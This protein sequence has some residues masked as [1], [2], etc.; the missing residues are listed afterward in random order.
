M[1]NEHGQLGQGAATEVQGSYSYT[2]DD[3]KT[4]SVHYKADANGGFQA[5]GDH[6][7]T[8]PPIPE[9]IQKSIA[10]NAANGDHGD[11][12]AY[13]HDAGQGAYNHQSSG[14]Y[15]QGG[16]QGAYSHQSGAFAQHGAGAGAGFGG[17]SS[18][19]SSGSRQQSYSS[20]TGYHY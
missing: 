4:Y 7:P 2:G 3:G 9:A 11:T 18:G 17:S 16:N 6:L 8:P 19:F 12:G 15:S 13:R 1:Q 14:G 5:V 20:N 10:L